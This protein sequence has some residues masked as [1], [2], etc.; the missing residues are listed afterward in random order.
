MS[1][2]TLSLLALCG[3][4]QGRKCIIIFSKRSTITVQSQLEIQFNTADRVSGLSPASPA[5][6]VTSICILTRTRHVGVAENLDREL[7][8]SSWECDSSGSALKYYCLGS[9]LELWLIQK[10]KMPAEYALEFGP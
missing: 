4:G 10:S 6:A 8:D 5:V 1:L 3:V 2:F 9:T 7:S